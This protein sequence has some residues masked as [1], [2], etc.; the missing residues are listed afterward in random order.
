M[1]VE[2]ENNEQNSFSFQIHLF[3]IFYVQE[4]R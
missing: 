4:Q 3:S 2:M 1:L